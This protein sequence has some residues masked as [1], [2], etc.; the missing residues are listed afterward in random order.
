MQQK[1]PEGPISTCIVVSKVPVNFLISWE[2]GGGRERERERER[3]RDRERERRGRERGGF[4]LIHY[5]LV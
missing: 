1:F 4:F 2:K 3:E 5:S